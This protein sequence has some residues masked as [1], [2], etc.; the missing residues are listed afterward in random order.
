[1]LS[2][3]F[4]TSEE[5]IG[6]LSSSIVQEKNTNDEFPKIP[7]L[8]VLSDRCVI[9]SLNERPSLKR[10]VGLSSRANL[11]K[12]KLNGYISS[13]TVSKIRSILDTWLSAI[14]LR[15]DEKQDKYEQNKYFPV[16]ITLTLCSV[17]KHDD[18]FVNRYLLQ[19]FLEKYKYH[20][21]AI[22]IFWRAESQKNGNIHYHIIGDRF[23][24]WQLIR[25]FW[26]DILENYGY[27]DEFEKEN[28]HRNPNSTDV[29]GAK[30]VKD[31]V[32]Y[33]LKYV[34]KVEEYRP[35]NC[36]LWGMTDSLRKVK[37]C[38]LDLDSKLS[39]EIGKVQK[40]KSTLTIKKDYVDVVL[41]RKSAIKWFDKSY[42]NLC[43]K[44]YLRELYDGLY[45]SDIIKVNDFEI[46]EDSVFKHAAVNRWV[47]LQLFS[48]EDFEG[49]SKKSFV[50]S[51]AF[52]SYW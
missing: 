6:L 4:T 20:T 30:D 5:S 42:I 44:T 46:I 51:E 36:R 43:Y 19:Q 25:K 3:R 16:F 50:N 41:F 10:H 26:N 23:I 7:F 47:Q 2:E 9:Y 29:K 33:V 52:E 38:T 17:Q 31:F 22:N 32:K 39:E 40:I 48:E 37:S 1:M 49:E 14:M 12:K 13:Y 18:K 35:L 27:I 24:K 28:K 15:V 34:S 8:K 45:C 11:T 21:G